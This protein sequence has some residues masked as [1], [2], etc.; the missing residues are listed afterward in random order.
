MTSRNVGFISFRISG[1]DGVSREA[2]KWAAVL[3]QLNCKSYFMAGELDNTSEQ[4]FL[5][6]KIHFQHPEIKNIYKES[7]GT[8]TRS[9][10][11]TSRIHEMRKYLKSRIYEFIETCGIDLLMPQNVLC[12]PLNIPLGLA[13]S[14]VIAETG[15][16]VV[17]HHHDFFW[18][19]KR[20][21]RNCVW[22][23]L[24]MAFPPH[25][26]NIEHVVINTAAQNQLALR[27][28]ISSTLIPNVMNFELG[29]PPKDNYTSSVR[30]DLGVKD[31]ELLI[32]QPTRVVQRKGIEHAIELVSRLKEKA[33][34][35]I[36]HA[37]SDEDYEYQKWIK[38]Y[39]D[40]M[41]IRAIFVNDIIQEQRGTTKDGR[42]IYV[43]ED[44]Y[45]CADLVTYPSLAEG[46][47]NA[48]LEAIWFRKPVMVNNYSIYST[49]IKPKGFKVIEMDN[50][51]SEATV[52]AVKNIL[53][54]PR[55]RRETAEINYKIALRHYS[56]GVLRSQLRAVLT[57]HWG[58]LQ[59]RN[60]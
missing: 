13:L 27:T 30:S 32:L 40:I 29:P 20:F 4:Y 17:A 34:L 22:D 59:P 36:S 15:I 21:L 26:N 2:M 47:G 37:S 50:Y 60:S 51:I 5:E 7:F 3:E 48:F 52:Q 24:N 54:N 14:E 58:N 53:N 9:R 18:E 42:K 49:D 11:L 43:L 33:V 57:C 6:E 12:L 23:Y 19:R 35:V 39:A 31:D 10:E 8:T 25:L 55:K 56:Y 28:G 38:E 46:F 41:K 44:I 16:P 1:T 45:P